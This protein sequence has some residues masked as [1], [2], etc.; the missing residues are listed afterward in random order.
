[1]TGQPSAGPCS[2]NAISRV[3]VRIVFMFTSAPYVG[4]AERN[5][6]QV[7]L[8]GRGL[9]SRRNANVA[10]QKGHPVFFALKL[11]FDSGLVYDRPYFLDQAI[12]K[13]IEYVFG[14]GLLAS[15][16]HGGRTVRHSSLSRLRTGGLSR[17]IRSAELVRLVGEDPDKPSKFPA[18]LKTAT[19]GATNRHLRSPNLF[20][21]ASPNLHLQPGRR[22]S[23]QRRQRKPAGRAATAPDPRQPVRDLRRPSLPF[24]RRCRK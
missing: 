5:A 2:S 7:E 8:H 19:G 11:R 20:W 10:D 24:R 9:V 6:V 18:A 17:P 1:M 21:G 14:E 15:R 12:S 16:S 3:S 22:S 4:Q 13:F 23:R